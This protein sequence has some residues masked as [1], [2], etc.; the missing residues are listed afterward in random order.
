MAES[1]ADFEESEFRGPLFNQLLRGN[2]LL[3]E[4]GQVF[5]E[6]IGIDYAALVE[7]ELFWRY[8]KGRFREGLPLAEI[9]LSYIWKKKKKGKVLPPFAL[10]LFIQAKRS[11]QRSPTPKKAKDRG[12]ATPC[13]FFNINQQQ[14]AALHRLS[15]ALKGKGLVCYAAPAF[16]SQGELYNHTEKRSIVQN[17]TFPSASKLQGHSRWYYDRAGT[18]GIANPQFER[19]DIG[20]IDTQIEALSN[21]RNGI[22]ESLSEN[23]D[24]LV[25]A[26]NSSIDDNP[27]EI[28]SRDTW[29]SYLAQ[30]LTD[31]AEE[32][33]GD[34]PTE[35]RSYLR[36]RAYCHAYNLEWLTLQ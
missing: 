22:S 34:I 3:W 18:F 36:V 6:H 20:H 2:N 10:N 21:Q 31:E 7:H 4:P 1:P 19:V 23:L 9:G 28:S 32:I 16:L 29:F 30:L 26:V 8:R 13:C 27:D 17:S 15:S 11:N 33:L 35:I 24:F 25:G 14:Q 12:L 5:E